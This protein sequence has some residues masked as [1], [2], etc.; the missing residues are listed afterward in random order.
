MKKILALFFILAI[1]AMAFACGGKS[2]NKTTTHISTTVQGLIPEITDNI[3]GTTR[4]TTSTTITSKITEILPGGGTD[5]TV[6]TIPPTIGGSTAV[7]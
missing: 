5:G 2:N 6:N 3:M 1:S 7:R 4:S